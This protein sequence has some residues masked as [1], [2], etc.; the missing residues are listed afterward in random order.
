MAPFYI[1]QLQ[2]AVGYIVLN[3]ALPA[4]GRALRD[5]FVA[6]SGS[7]VVREASTLQLHFPQ[8][9]PP[10]GSDEIEFVFNR[11]FVGPTKPL[12]P[13]FASIYL[14]EDELVM[15]HTTMEVRRFYSVLGL[16]SPWHGTLPEDHIALEIDA[17]LYLQQALPLI[18]PIEQEEYL[19][20]CLSFFDQH[21]LVWVPRF[22]ERV[23]KETARGSFMHTVVD[24]LE[25]WLL[26]LRQE[27]SCWEKGVIR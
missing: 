12:A 24:L 27:I 2:I 6:R 20:L 13:P 26:E 22:C 8:L 11:L 25:H 7:E 4:I 5:L 3:Y 10:G 18:Q 14:E 1:I 23:R 9:P 21:V 16:V 19:P 15:S 17:C